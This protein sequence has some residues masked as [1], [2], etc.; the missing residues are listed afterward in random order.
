V[1]FAEEVRRMAGILLR[2]LGANL[3]G[4]AIAMLA[5]PAAEVSGQTPASKPTASSQGV[6][7]SQ[8]TQSSEALPEGQSDAERVTRL[9]RTIDENEKRLGELK[10]KLEQPDGEYAKAEADFKHVDGELE[11]KK[12]DLQNLRESGK[13]AEADALQSEVDGLA[14]R[15]EL[16][17]VRF[18]LAIQE[19]KVLQEQVQTIEQKL[20]QDRDAL[21]QLL[22]PPPVA[23]QPAKPLETHAAPTA[24][25][26]ANQ[27]SATAENPPAAPAVVP[28]S[29]VPTPKEAPAKAPEAAAPEGAP[30]K[31]VSTAPPS[32]ELI[33]AQDEAKNKAAQAAQAEQQVRS[34]AERIDNAEERIQQERVLLE[35]ARKKADNARETERTLSEQA[36]Q[37]WSE[38]APQAELH[39]LWGQI[40]EARTRYKQAQTEVEQKR[41]RV[42][43]L[44]GEL[45]QLQA[46]RI[47]TL[48]KADAKQKEAEE[49]RKKVEWLN[50]PL[51]PRNMLRWMVEHGPRVMGIIAGM[52]ALLWLARRAEKHIVR[53]LA[54]RS[55]L[56]TQEDRENRAQTL[57]S[58]FDSAATVAVIGGG[59]LM[60]LTEL[61][62]NI[63]PLMGGAAVVGLA[64]AFGAQNLI[65]D[66]FYGFMILLESQYTVN[67]VVK[68]GDVSGQVERITLRVTVLRGLDGTVHFVP[69]GQITRVSNM[70]HN[71]SRALFDIP[72]AY[73]E[74]VDQVMEVLTDLAKEM[75]RDP[76]YRGLILEMP[77]ML[78]VD[79]FADS[80][81]II[82]FFIKTRPLKQ[83]TVKREL[84]R[85]IKKR[86]DALGIEIPFPHRTVFHRY[87][88]GVTGEFDSGQSGA[89]RR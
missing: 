37:R 33:K 2:G 27:N 41:D 16:A 13:T 75:R 59:S 74:D 34:V 57:V 21:Q 35:N 14:K 61:G 56:G 89:A 10:A 69:N 9:T 7:T 20:I 36:Q 55:E 26:A 47:A 53:L 3:A 48:Q 52:F 78:G 8:A 38:G 12:K 17:K 60:V 73:K 32:P 88:N 24:P 67:D 6:P 28:G 49:A 54:G 45:R 22:A 84:L 29:P 87:E 19:R 25:A 71:W 76:E 64:V 1:R 82:K 58:V 44:E 43:E 42:D 70:T 62:V 72:V 80:A 5:L 18:D 11:A 68:I 66:Y 30:S 46:E 81:V 39:D 51:A 77:E 50:S 4:L 31:P 79:E 65:R 15:R 86:F 85:R 40:A 63:I 23:S 83:W